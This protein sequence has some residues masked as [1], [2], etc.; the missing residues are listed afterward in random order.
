VKKNKVR[1]VR[2]DSVKLKIDSDGIKANGSDIQ[3]KIDD[4]NGVEI[5][6]KNDN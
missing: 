2:S 6:S 5:K 1:T 4:K 3:V